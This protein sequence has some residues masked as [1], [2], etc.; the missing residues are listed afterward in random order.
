MNKIKNIILTFTFVIFIFAISS[1][2]ILLPDEEYSLSER[3][4]L[5]KTPE[6]NISTVSSGEFM[7]NFEKYSADQ[8][9]LRDKFRGIKAFFS[10]KVMRK[11]DNN[12]LFY[13]DG[14][15]S[16]IDN[17]ENNY[18]MNY[19]SEL[20]AKIISSNMTDKN[21][22][23]YFSIV[24][25]KN[26]FIAE[27][28]GYPSLDYNGF[29][30]RMRNKTEYM[31]YIDITSLLSK[32]DY[33]NTDTHWKQENITDIAQHLASEM[34]ANAKSEY[35]VNTLD[36][37]FYGVYSGQ[38]TL[39]VKPDTI[40]YLTNDTIDNCIVTYYGEGM[41]EK[42]EMYNME[43]AYGKDPYEMFLSGVAPLITIENPNA[44]TDKELVLF[45]DSFGSSIAPLL[46]EGYSKITV[47][48][49]RYIQSS[50]VGNFVDFENCDVLFLYSTAILNNSTAMK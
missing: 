4:Y 45:R 35:K 30:E 15:I 41:P 8:F 17:D 10:T 24:P 25:D 44:K 12:G 31:K 36:N 48:D 28:N 7:K 2:C 21:T 16:K 37:P 23:V 34:G 20:F 33:Y 50:F 14:H 49:I 46:L 32:D 1:A 29:I 13:T 47:V 38:Y 26:Y 18:M 42:G 3:R 9:P 22:N 19:A 39:P 27:K 5:E 11:L 6:L 43:K 40:K